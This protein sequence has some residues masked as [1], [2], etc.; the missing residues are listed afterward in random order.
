MNQAQKLKSTPQKKEIFS[1]DHLGSNGIHADVNRILS[2][3]SDIAGKHVI[4]LAC[5]DGRTTFLLR[6]LGAVVSPYD[7]FPEY[8][9]LDDLP[10]FA[11]VQQILPIPDKSADIVI[12][13][14]VIEHLPNQLFTLQE[15]FRILKPGGELF[16]TTPSRSSLE[17]RLAYLCF[18]SENIKGTPW[19][20]VDAVWGSDSSG[21]KKYYGHLWLIGVQQ[22]K[23]LSG[24][25]GFHSMHV[26]ATKCSK[27]SIVFMPFFYPLILL[28]SLRALWRDIRNI[29]R[30]FSDPIEINE[31]RTEKIEQFKLNINMRNML[32]KYF[33]ASLRK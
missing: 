18:E 4:D 6:K 30:R 19:G 21:G 2:A 8:S 20:S 9:K 14:E 31:Y 28:I 1:F 27:S 16:L 13:Q 24:V 5:G 32:N 3:R 29:R 15:I 17:A 7:I 11:D 23:A 22:L 26:Y 10:G 12:L 25:A 33:I